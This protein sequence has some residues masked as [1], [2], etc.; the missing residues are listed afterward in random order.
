MYVPRPLGK[1]V[2]QFW[3]TCMFLAEGSFAFVR[4]SKVLFRDDLNHLG[5]L[6]CRADPCHTLALSL[7]QSQGGPAAQTQA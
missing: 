1:C 4:F 3:P 7:T 6:V 2:S 5:P